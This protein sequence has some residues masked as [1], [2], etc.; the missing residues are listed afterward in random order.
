MK[1][2]VQ[3][4]SL[5][6]LKLDLNDE[7]LL[8]LHFS[9]CFFDNFKAKPW[10]LLDTLVILPNVFVYVSKAVQMAVPP[11]TAVIL[12]LFGIPLYRHSSMY[13]SRLLVCMSFENKGFPSLVFMVVNRF[14][15]IHICCLQKWSSF[16]WPFTYLV[17]LV[18]SP[19]Y[20]FY[21]VRWEKDLAFENRKPA[22]FLEEY[23]KLVMKTFL[24]EYS[25][26]YSNLLCNTD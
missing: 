25:K 3:A 17:N 4:T 5:E 16:S 21:E 14:L 18:S 12:S 23:K 2:S 1:F 13:L 7:R 20:I 24:V 11:L 19:A 22:I 10:D 8:I 26:S 6:L 9:A 15:C